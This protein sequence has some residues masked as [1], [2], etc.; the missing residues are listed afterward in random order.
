VRE[1]LAE[2][3]D[4]DENEHGK[5]RKKKILRS[6]KSLFT[7]LND[8]WERGKRGVH[9]ITKRELKATKGQQGKLVLRGPV[10]VERSE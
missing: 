5:L 4:V 2:K 9:P 10:Q 7:R 1:V 6:S 8:Y 3:R